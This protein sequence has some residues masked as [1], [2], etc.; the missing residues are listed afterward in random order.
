MLPVTASIARM[1]TE[2]VPPYPS[3][4]MDRL[5]GATALDHRMALVT[6]DKAIR[7]SKLVETIW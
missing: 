4:P 2:F 1:A 6:K 3:D 7:K 5:I